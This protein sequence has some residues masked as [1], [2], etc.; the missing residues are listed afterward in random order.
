MKSITTLKVVL[1]SDGIIITTAITTST[2]DGINREDI[3]SKLNN[4][5]VTTGDDFT[6]SLRLV[7]T[8]ALPTGSPLLGKVATLLASTSDVIQQ[9]K[10]PTFQPTN[11][12][13]MKPTI[14]PTN[15]VRFR[16]SHPLRLDTTIIIFIVVIVI[17]VGFIIASVFVYFWW[18]KRGRTNKYRD[19]RRVVP[20]E[21]AEYA[22]NHH[23][24]MNA[25]GY[26]AF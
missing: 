17:G 4:P 19:D 23:Q 8:S 13:L 3:N 9:S 15:V 12:V 10:I 14:S 20:I 22:N 6:T 18:R 1:L 2:S 25:G 5:S 21:D 24:Q 7:L 11:I 26:T 16:S